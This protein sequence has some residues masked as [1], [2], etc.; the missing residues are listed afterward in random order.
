MAEL[1]GLEPATSAV[2]GQRSNQLSYNSKRSGRSIFFFK[3][4]ANEFLHFFQN[5]RAKRY[6]AR[7]A[8][9]KEDRKPETS[10]TAA[11]AQTTERKACWRSTKN[12]STKIGKSA[13]SE[14]FTFLMTEANVASDKTAATS[15]Y[16]NPWT[17]KGQ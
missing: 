12:L 8:N 2:T 10:A 1:T 4:V 5:P 17:A 13:R 3:M 14:K 16:A 6:P 9:R 15:A 11:R 7:L